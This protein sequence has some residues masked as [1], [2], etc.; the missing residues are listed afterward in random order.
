MSTMTEQNN[1]ETYNGYA[2]RETWAF[3][4]HWQ[5][6]QGMYGTTLDFAA[7]YVSDC[8]TDRREVTDA[9]IGGAVVDYWRDVFDG[10]DMDDTPMPRELRMFQR[11]VGSWWRIDY[12]EVGE[13][14]RESLDAEG[15]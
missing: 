9:E 15:L 2:N 8:T 10:Y 14:V 12:R 11:E 4:L 3:N 5:N 1:S 13:A 7:R 6:D